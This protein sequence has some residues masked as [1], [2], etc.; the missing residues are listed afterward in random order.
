MK[1]TIITALQKKREI[2]YFFI[3]I[4]L[5]FLLNVYAIIRYD[6][7]WKEL[8]TQLP[9]VLIWGCALWVIWLVF[10]WVFWAVV[11]LFLKMKKGY[12]YNK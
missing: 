5:A 4:G 7:E 6:T 10:R 8:W 12:F 11:K 3:C 1:D 9:W 2:A